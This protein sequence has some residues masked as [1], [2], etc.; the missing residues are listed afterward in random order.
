MN[1]QAT[2]VR[3]VQV[4]EHSTRVHLRELFIAGYKIKPVYVIKTTQ[5]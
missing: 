3:D 5:V 4:I 1:M 2:I